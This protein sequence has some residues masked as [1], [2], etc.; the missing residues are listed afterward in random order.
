MSELEEKT[1]KYF[2]LSNEIFV[3]IYIFAVLFYFKTLS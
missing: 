3:F 1:W 2:L